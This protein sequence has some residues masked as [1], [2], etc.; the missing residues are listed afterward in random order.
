MRELPDY[1][2]PLPGP[3]EGSAASEATARA[4]QPED[5]GVP[6][7]IRPMQRGHSGA[8]ITDAIVTASGV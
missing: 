2:R 3:N 5:S 6:G 1:L 8:F 4:S 7:L